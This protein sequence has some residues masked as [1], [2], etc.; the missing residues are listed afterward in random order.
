MPIRW[1]DAG[2]VSALRSQSIYHG[3]GYAQK[4]GTEN[5]IVL[6]TPESPYMCIGHFQDARNELDLEFCKKQNLPIIRRETGGGTVYIDSDQLFVQWIFQRGYLPPKVEH[7][8]QF[9]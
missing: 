9:F 3:L 2:K 6:A 1:I 8:F 7:R 4:D 5:T